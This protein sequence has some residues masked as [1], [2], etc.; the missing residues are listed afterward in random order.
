MSRLLPCSL[1]ICGI[2]ELDGFA[3]VGVS[4]VL[5]ILDPA[6][7][8]PP[9]FER[10]RPHRRTTL[11]FDDV[12]TEVDGH[13]LP[14]ADDVARVLAFGRELAASEPLHLLV[15]CHAG[16]SRSTAASLILMAQ[17]NPGRERDIFAELVEI[18]PRAWPNSRMI[19]FADAMLGCDG[20]L[21]AALQDHYKEAVKRV[22][23][24]GDMIRAIK[25]RAHEVPG[26]EA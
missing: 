15:H 7:P 17:A 26:I 4:H 18:R 5:S 9:A 24:L 3:R 14:V 21:S 25:H 6:Y 12:V 10:F 2:E 20:R 8:D 16:V 23:G 13:R 1:T 22:P 11:R 19:G